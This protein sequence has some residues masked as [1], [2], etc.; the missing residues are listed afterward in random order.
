MI[1]ILGI[2]SLVVIYLKLCKELNYDD[3]FFDKT[4][5]AKMFYLNEHIYH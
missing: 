4:F 3:S 2:A 5:E 1:H